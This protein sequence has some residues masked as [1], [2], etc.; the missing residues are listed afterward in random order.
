MVHGLEAKYF[1]QIIFSYIDADD[2]RTFDIQ[3]ALGFRSQPELYLLDAAGNVLQK[4]VG[5]TSQEQL[6]SAFTQYLP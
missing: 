2:R 6:E 1:G 5:F 3:R 4:F